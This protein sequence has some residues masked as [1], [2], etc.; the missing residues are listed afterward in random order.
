VISAR[1][2]ERVAS[3]H[4]WIYR[5]DVADVR[6]AAGDIVIVRSPRGR[7]LGSAFYSVAHAGGRRTAG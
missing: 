6:A 7:T 5:G 1:G 2:E 3:G 4:P